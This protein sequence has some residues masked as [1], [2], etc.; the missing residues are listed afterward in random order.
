[1]LPKIKEKVI[2]AAVLLAMSLT[3]VTT[4]SF[5]WFVRSVSPEITGVSTT[6]AANGNLEIALADSMDPPDDSSSLDGSLSAAKKNLTWGNLINLSDA[7][8]GLDNLTLKPAQLNTSA[9]ATSP[10]YGAEY[11]ASGRVI[12]LVSNFGYAV[13]DNELEHKF[14]INEETE[15]MRGVRSISSVT[16]T[17]TGVVPEAVLTFD[18]LSEDIEA[19]NL[20]AI[21]NYL[22][23]ASSDA[24]N[25][26][27]MDSLATMI[28]LFMTAKMNA[29]QGDES[30][31]NPTVDRADVQNIRNLYSLF[32][33][34]FELEAD[35]MAQML[36]LQVF[37]KTGTEG[38][39]TAE[40]VLTKITAAE[41]R[42]AGLSLSNIKQYQDDYVKIKNSIA[43]LDTVLGMSGTIK[44][45]DS[46]INTIVA[47]LVNVGTCTLDGTPV[48]NIGVSNATQY[49][50][51]KTH[52]A[53]IT[54]G[55][56][57]NFERRTGAGIRVTN[58]TVS[59]KVKR[60]GMTIPA[61][62]SANITTN[63]AA[64][65]ASFFA[66]D[67]AATKAMNNI[68]APM[69]QVAGDTFGLAVDFWVRTNASG[70]FLILEGNVLTETVVVPVTGKDMTGAVVPLYT[71]DVT[72]LNDNEEEV[73]VQVD[74]YEKGDVWYH[75]TAHT[76]YEI[77]EGKIPLA[78]V[79][80]KK[81]PVGYEGANRVWEGSK[82]LPE[83]ST[84]QGSGSCYTFYSTGPED[85]LRSLKILD[86][87]NIV[88][89][90]STGKLLATAEMDV[91]MAYE[92]GG[93]VTV[94]LVL[95]S[96]SGIE[97]GKDLEGNDVRAIMPLEK[98]VATFVTALVYLDGTRLTNN[99]VLAASDIQGKLNIQFGTTT[100]LVPLGNQV[101]FDES[102]VLLASA[103]KTAFDYDTATEPMTTTVSVDLGSYKASTL[104]A[105]FVR[106]ISSTQGSK[107]E[108]MTF[109]KGADGKWMTSYTF[110]APGK[111]VLRSVE[112][113][114]I[115]RELSNSITVN[116]EGFAISD[117]IWEHD[118]EDNGAT[119]MTADGQVTETLKLKFAASD[120]ARMPKTV[121]GRFLKDDGTVAN[122]NFTYDT[123]T[124][125]W[126]GNVTFVTSGEYTLQFLVLDGEYVELDAALQ[127]KINLYLGMKVTVYTSS[128]TT[129]KYLDSEMT[130]DMRNLHMQVRIADDT[131]EQLAGLSSAYDVYLNY[132]LQSSSAQ[133]I[134]AKLTWNGESGYYEGDFTTHKPGIYV[135][136]S[137][138]VG[139]N[140]ITV[141]NYS[142]KFTI[143]SPN[144]P[145]YIGQ[146]SKKDSYQYNTAG[147][148]SLS[149]RLGY[150]STATVL[151][152][153]YNAEQNK[154]YESQATVLG[155]DLGDDITEWN[156][157]IPK[158]D[159]LQDGNWQ[160]MELNV[161]NF[162][163]SD[164]ITYISAEVDENGVLVAG[165]ERD[166][167]KV[168]DLEDDEI[169][170]KVVSKI[171]LYFTE[172]LSDDFEGT[173]LE[174][175]KVNGLNLV[176]EDFEGQAIP[177]VK[178]V[179][180]VFEH[181]GK[182][183]EM[184]GYSISDFSNVTEGATIT[185]LLEANGTHYEQKTDAV[186]LFAGT[187]ATSIQYSLTGVNGDTTNT[188]K[189]TLDSN[190]NKSLANAPMFSVSSS[191]PTVKITG[192]SP[193]T[194]K[195]YYPTATPSKTGQL[196]DGTFYYKEDYYAAVYIYFEKQ[197]GLFAQE[198]YAPKH[199]TVSLALTGVPD[200][201]SNVGMT[202]NHQSN[203][204]Y[205][206]KFNFTYDSSGKYYKATANIGGF[207]AGEY[208]ALDSG[209]FPKLF[210]AGE[211]TVDQVTLTY[212]SLNFTVDLSHDVTINNPLV[213]PKA[214]YKDI[215]S[216]ESSYPGSTPAAVRSS[217]AKTITLPKASDITVTWTEN[218]S[219]TVN[220]DFTV[221]SGYPTTR[222]VYT[223][224]TEGILFWA[225]T[226]Y[227]PYI[228]TT[229]VSVASS[230]TITWVDT[231]TITGW[232]VGNKT[233]AFG[234]T[235]SVTGDITV[236]PII[237]TVAGPKTTT[238]STTT[239]TTV[240]YTANGSETT[241]KP[242]G[243]RVTSVENTTNDV[244][245]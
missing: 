72:T 216:V 237:S 231:H 70:G 234:E 24:D 211:A 176:I 113:D 14:V 34:T 205:N 230:S 1:V 11:D 61:S 123:K 43:T 101:L 41:L 126:N 54:N 125:F 59:A 66:T 149:V 186:F 6:F 138:T 31:T 4:V 224:R 102:L 23:L 103:D 67:F 56:I 25:K 241:T 3:M 117:V 105:F 245:S 98:N 80:E 147:T 7:S 171:Y 88:F 187:Y 124:S 136:E 39:Y 81:V 159:G 64:A 161:W 219:S 133:T 35:A 73:T 239:R 228:E 94:P 192:V 83:N 122:V 28:G 174:S 221:Q 40:D 121:E 208:G 177:V 116:I 5:A 195:R 65:G 89:I 141:T 60:L 167:P 15:K 92:S 131:G 185:T 63:A 10:L 32:S 209:T 218:R 50:D 189:I 155:Q 199:P 111:Y 154:I 153:L 240:T 173:F 194:E 212:N 115:E 130:D 139:G 158:I 97:L 242:S 91:E 44:W 96:D 45:Q 145:I 191:A 215:A 190:G 198:A 129:F 206:A 197:S 106:E 71:V 86:A 22:A 93:K 193:T 55:I 29:G 182:M 157:E 175:H 108:K 107:E 235:I 13:Y 75:A 36:N 144:P 79:E 204:A 42:G 168:F 9:L 37:L 179:K 51:G 118:D 69:I 180:L 27:K 99:E 166:T 21:N 58:L 68:E 19:T 30:L 150:S 119:V 132:R 232:K 16:T 226:Y 20:A 77:P 2:A 128:P 104:T 170:T 222:N 120:T 52:N 207:V 78:K 201:A 223:Q 229:T 146:G 100:E 202:F 95:L 188:I 152:K 163:E 76:P 162:Y 181:S 142:P 160:L 156:I 172:D 109:I 214:T 184:G 90:D 53:V 238:S 8:Y 62:I 196:F 244:V 26:A 200:G 178:D 57:Y 49:L 210:S 233:Y 47:N 203:A 38:I 87:M 114:G 164:G 74:L 127:K 227:T 137:V 220:Q 225:T 33:D 183:S 148:A 12:K 85:Q 151:A 213:P 243:T 17:Y 18:R 135:F 165:G 217:D 46:G 48:N 140:T 84:T 110:D 236:T 134:K 143:I 82:G 112:I 169:K